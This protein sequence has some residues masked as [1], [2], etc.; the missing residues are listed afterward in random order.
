M[1]RE[2]DLDDEQRAE[3]EQ[4]AADQEGAD[5]RRPGRIPDR[6]EIV[7]RE[8]HGEAGDHQL[9][10]RVATLLEAAHR[11]VGPPPPGPV[12]APGGG[13]RRAPPHHAPVSS[14]L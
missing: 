8:R 13:G 10:A 3:A 11:H 14:G 12:G 6:R 4:D 9:P 7:E 2:D 1:H 5:L